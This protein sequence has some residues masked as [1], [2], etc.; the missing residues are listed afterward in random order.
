MKGELN[1]RGVVR[2]WLPLVAAFPVAAAAVVIWQAL[3]A[4]ESEHIRQLAAAEASRVQEQIAGSIE[5]QTL[6]AREDTVL[7]EATLAAGLLVAFLL[8]ATLYEF[9]KARAWAHRLE[10]TH[11]QRERAEQ[12]YRMT[13]ENCPDAFIA[14]D[15]AGVIQQWNRQAEHIFGWPRGEV[16]GQ[17]VRDV[18]VPPEHREDHQ[19]GLEHFLKTGEGPLLNRRIEVES[20]RKDGSRFPIELTITP[21]ETFEGWLF[22]AFARDI[23]QR[24]RMEQRFH[25]TIES[26]PTA[27]VMIDSAGE[28]VL[29]NSETERLFGYS[30]DELLGRQVELL[31]PA[32]FRPQHPRLRAGFFAQPQARR[33]GEGRDLF[34]L[35]K[36]GTEFPVEIGLNPVET[37]EGLFVLGAIVDI[38][39]R[40]QAE[41]ELRHL[42]ETLEQRVVERTSKLQAALDELTRAKEAAEEASRAKSVFLANMSHEV[43]T[44]L[45]GVIGMAELLQDTP[46]SAVQRDYLNLLRESGESLL[47]V[48]NDI[49]DFSKI[50]AGRL[51]LDHVPFDYA[52]SVGDTM[53]SLGL[54][55]HAKGLELALRIAPG[56][57]RVLIGDPGRL[58]QVLVNLV[59][60]AIKFTDRGEVVVDV[61]AVATHASS[62][63]GSARASTAPAAEPTGDAHAG[64]SMVELH[65][66]VRDTGIGIAADKLESIFQPFE[67]ADGTTT[68]RFGGTGLGLAISVRLVGMMGGRIWAESEPGRGSTFHFTATFEAPRQQPVLPQPAAAAVLRDLPVLVVDDNA[69]NRR[70]LAETLAAWGAS[71]T[72]AA[73]AE[74]ALAALRQAPG[75]IR[76][77]I[78]DMHMPGVDGFELVERIKQDPE[79]SD[80]T[81]ILM[82]SS[83]DQPG[84]VARCDRMGIACYLIKPIKQSELYD[85]ILM[86]LGMTPVDEA[87]EQERERKA[88]AAQADRLQRRSLN[89]LLAED[90][91]VNQKLAV[92]LLTKYGHRVDVAE[93]GREA[94]HRYRRGAYDLVLMDVQ[95]PEMDGLEAT[96]VIRAREEQTGRHTPIIAMTAYAMKGDRE[97]CLAAGMD[98]YLSKPVRPGEFFDK[99]GRLMGTEQPAVENDPTDQDERLRH[100]GKSR[101]KR[102]APPIDWEAALETAMGDPEILRGLASDFLKEGAALLHQMHEAVEAND[103]ELLQRAAHSAKGDCRIFGAAVAEHIA[104]HIENTA[105]DGSVDVAEA[106]AGLEQQIKEIHAELREFLAGR[107]AL[108]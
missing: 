55:A 59:G 37:D 12:R 107:V 18:I 74:A 25:A 98:D 51:E 19:R 22:A 33:M 54:R 53:K 8:G 3:A 66:S 94:V 9:L 32:R 1:L 89:I 61:E 80:G 88:V 44:P 92:R 43:R 38:T 10:E 47:T 62:A 103:V 35:R 58:R 30:R 87:S 91:P 6:A 40:K 99:I 13:L 86:A 21:L 90:S 79:I 29:V 28:I 27:M 57:P 23:T 17:E 64:G 85:A 77:V 96:K 42:N 67:Q 14:M 50:E 68:R 16:V 20:L 45:N 4:R 76:L 69:A 41:A 105:R 46:L 60:N 36:E 104:F 81:I 56:V 70:I 52:E 15:Q 106:L 71:P 34:G 63:A 5:A 49:L 39:E 24:K 100:G 108:G 48:I 101:T 75:R 83:G 102:R 73:G 26:A 97:R 11:L 82:L 78:T 2:R 95:M 84:D 31:V 72:T 7:P 65:A 93:N